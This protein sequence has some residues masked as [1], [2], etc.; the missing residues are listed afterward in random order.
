MDEIIYK[1]Y[2]LSRINLLK[3]GQLKTL[4]KD[5]V[6]ITGLSTIDWSHPIW[7]QLSLLCDRVVRIVKSQTYVF[8]DSV[9]CLGGISPDES[10]ESRWNS[11][12][13]ISQDSRI[14]DEIQKMMAESRGEPEQFQGRIIFMSIYNDIVWEEHREI[15]KICVANSKNVAAYANK[16]PQG[17]WTFMGL[18]EKK[19]YGTHV[20]TPN[21][22]S[23]AEVMMLNFAASGHPVFRAT[24]ASERGELKSKGG[25]KKSIHLNGS[26]ETVDLV[27]RTV[28]S[29]NQLSIYGAL[30]DL[31]K[32]PDPDSRN[33]TEGEIC[34]S[35]VIPTD[36]HNANTTSQISTS[37]AQGDLLQEYEREFAELPIRNCRNCAP[38]LVSYRKLG[39]DN[40]SSQLRK[41]LR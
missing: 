2:D 39:K 16:F 14:L 15:M 10:A 20:I 37:L 17:C 9:L 22:D 6:E 30:A 12:G 28:I 3:S 32:G 29:V 13:Q 25:G 19:W 26:E 1:T 40:S 23:T 18:V 41:D 7:T 38:T 34:E 35:S 8:A 31:C 21:V 27:L 33:Q 11:S 4:F 24:S 36:I 5:Q